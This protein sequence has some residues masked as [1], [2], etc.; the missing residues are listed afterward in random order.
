MKAR[1]A[2][3]FAASLVLAATVRA[4]DPLPSWNDTAPKKS[5]IEFVEKVTKAGSADFVPVPERIATFDNDGCLWAEQPMYFQV[6]FIFERIKA[7]APEHPEWKSTEPARKIVNQAFTAANLPAFGPHAFRHIGLTFLTPAVVSEAMPSTFAIAAGY[8]DF[9]SGLLAILAL[10]ALQKN[11]ASAIG[12][13][14]MFSIVGS[15][16]LLNALRQVEAVPHF[17]AAWYI[18]TF[19]VPL[20]IVTHAMVFARLVKRN[21]ANHKSPQSRPA[22]VH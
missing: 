5:I 21:Q 3:Q 8:G 20:L 6:I 15:V 18:P 22:S 16:D 2:L 4:A 7:L 11:W 19:L 13:V 12:I 1:I 17:G 14:W 9:I 10:L